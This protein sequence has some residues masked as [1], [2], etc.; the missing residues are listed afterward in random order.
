[1]EER[2]RNILAC[3]NG[4]SGEKLV[5][6][7]LIYPYPV[8]VSGKE[9]PIENCPRS[10][11]IGFT[12]NTMIVRAVRIKYGT[13]ACRRDMSAGPSSSFADSAARFM[14]GLSSSLHSSRYIFILPIR[15][16]ATRETQDGIKHDSVVFTW[17][18]KSSPPPWITARI[19]TAGSPFFT[20][21]P[22]P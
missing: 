13:N 12:T 14:I 4:T 8:A 15:N 5:S 7:S 18:S 1:M 3:V 16:N 20:P 17:L 21:F 2:N 10:S 9:N 6:A 11:L 19:M 22:F